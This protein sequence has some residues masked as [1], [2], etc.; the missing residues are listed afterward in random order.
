MKTLAILSGSLVNSLLKPKSLG[1]LE[2]EF[3][4]DMMLLIP[5]HVVLRFLIL[6]SKYFVK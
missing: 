6:D 1:E 3:L 2:A 5:I 4:N